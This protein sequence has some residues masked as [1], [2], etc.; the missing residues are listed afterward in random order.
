MKAA[1]RLLATLAVAFGLSIALGIIPFQVDDAFIAYRYAARV[2]AGE[3]FSYSAGLPPTEGFSSPIWV[4][5][6]AAIAGGMGP[7][8]IATAALAA[9]L[10][11]YLLLLALAGHD[12]FR[13]ASTP[14]APGR[15]SALISISLLAVSFTSIFYAVTG[16]E[17]LLFAA[18]AAAFALAVAGEIPLW[19]GM[20]AGFLAPWT[21][22]EGGWLLVAMLAQCAGSRSWLPMREGR[23]A[24][25]AGSVLLGGAI[26]VAARLATFGEIFPNTFFAKQPI[27][28]EG[29]AY[30]L[31]TFAEPALAALV[32]CAAVGA[33]LG[34]RTRAG[35]LAAGI[36]WIAAAVAEG[37]DWMPAGRMLLPAVT[38]LALAAGGIAWDAVT[39][40]AENRSRFRR[41]AVSAMAI[42]AVIAGAAFSW[43]AVRDASPG[44]AVSEAE[45][46]ALTD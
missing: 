17:T 2:G 37:G 41:R 33:L 21:R 15:F 43:S 20:G 36:T 25:L 9:G 23:G 26:L 18:I 4:L 31:A 12:L 39:A 13:F 45:T 14:D 11:S 32:G 44:F 34:D 5:G 8:S 10:A 7:E 1:P 28:G 24:R 46:T 40:A 27:F 3:G 22:P 35:Y 30:V 42:C 38:M 16:L 6:L 19:M 29:W